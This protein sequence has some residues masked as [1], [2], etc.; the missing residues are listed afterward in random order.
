M[1]LRISGIGSFAF[2][3][4][5]KH[6]VGRPPVNPPFL[7]ARVIA[8]GPGSRYAQERCLGQSFTVCRFAK[9]LPMSVDDF[10]WGPGVDN[11]V[12]QTASKDERRALADQDARFAVTA[13]AAYPLQ[14]V[15]ASARN[16][17]LQLVDTDLGDFNYDSHVRADFAATWPAGPRAA[18]QTSLAYRQ[19][20][21]LQTMWLL[22]TVVL[23]GSLAAIGV[24]ATRASN[25][26]PALLEPA[27]ALLLAVLIIVGVLANGAVCG[28]LSTLYG[29]YQARVVWL[30]PLAAVL[31]ALVR[32]RSQER[33]VR[34]R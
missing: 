13:A 15:T 27:D 17:A 29:R 11:G 7:T 16:A 24:M 12:F 21:P 32:A 23:L 26:G 22:Q 34:L 30:I 9:R 5:V 4:M 18:L 10:L 8:D 33:T 28:V 3:A 19:A 14:Q 2:S 6:T 1:P 31:L 20:W 25:S